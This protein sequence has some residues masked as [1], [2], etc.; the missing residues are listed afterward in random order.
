M[1]TEQW[2]APQGDR[3]ENGEEAPPLIHDGSGSR[4][5]GKRSFLGGRVVLVPAR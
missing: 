1:A 4:E 2:V 3:I 5:G